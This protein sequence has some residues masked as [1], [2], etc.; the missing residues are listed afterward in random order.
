MGGGACRQPGGSLEHGHRW[1]FELLDPRHGEGLWLTQQELIQH[2]EFSR[3][4]FKLSSKS[5]FRCAT[6][7]SPQEAADPRPTHLPAY[8]S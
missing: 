1:R 2:F 8:R 6:S 5:S 7:I 3:A 4:S